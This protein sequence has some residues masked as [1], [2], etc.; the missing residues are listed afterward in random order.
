MPAR[1]EGQCKVRCQLAV[2]TK[3]FISIHCVHGLPLN[4]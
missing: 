2:R 3:W 4:V 1:Y